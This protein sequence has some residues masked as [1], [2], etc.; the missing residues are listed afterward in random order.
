M[1]YDW[2]TEIAELS[3]PRTEADLVR[4]FLESPALSDSQRKE[5]KE[6]A[7]SIV[8]EVRGKDGAGPIER[9]VAG[10]DLTSDEGRA[11]MGLAEALV[12]VPD[13]RTRD[14]LIEDKVVGQ[15]WF[16]SDADALVKAAGLALDAAGHFIRDDHTSALHSAAHRLGMPVIRSS[17]VAAMKILGDRFVKAET[18]EDAVISAERTQDVLFSFDMLGEGARSEEDAKRHLASYERAIRTVAL[19]TVPTGGAQTNSGVS[20]KL[21]ALHC[22]YRAR[23]WPDVREVLLPR[24]VRLASLA[25][26]GNIPLAI[27]A[28]ESARLEVSLTLI[29]ELLRVPELADWDGLGIVLQ[30]YGLRAGEFLDAVLESVAE[31]GRQISVRLVKGAYWDSEI[32]LA[33]EKGLETFP[34]YTRKAHSDL[35]YLALARR[36]LEC[37]EEVF[38][39][40]ATHNAVTL[41]ALEMLFREKGGNRF[42]VQKL[43]GMGDAV[44]T[45]YHAKCSRHLRAYAPVGSQDDLLAYLVRRLLENAANASFLHQLGDA[46]VSE[47]DLVMDPYEMAEGSGGTAIRTG[48]GLFGDA[49]QNSRGRDLDRIEVLKA[50]VSACGSQAELPEPP[51]DAGAGD[52]AGA[53]EAAQKA[54]EEWAA[55]G[56]HERAAAIERIADGYEGA[57][58]ELLQL[59]VREAGKTMGDAVAELREAVDYCRY[60]AARARELP[61][62]AVPRGT[63]VAISPWNFPLAIFT[64]QVVAALAAGNAVVAKPA[65]QTPRVAAKA[66]DIMHAAGV[67]AGAMQLLCGPGGTVGARLVGAGSADMVAFTG[68]TE[69]ARLIHR[70]IAESAK[71]AAPLLAETAGI[72]A[73]VVDSTA[74]P[75]R[76]VDD[77]A[78][79][80][81][82]SAG[83]RCSSL[84]VLYLQEEVSERITDL[85]IGAASLLRVGD[86]ADPDTD[87]GPVIDAEAKGR[88]DEHVAKASADGSLL[89]Q[90]KAPADGNYCAPAII[91]V[92]GAADVAREVFGPVLHVATYPAGS[93][94]KVVDAINAAGYGLTMG[95]HSRMR[96]KQRELAGRAR[97]GNVYVNRNQVGAVVGCQ[98]FG[99]SGLSGTG[100]KAGGPLYLGAFTANAAPA[101]SEGETRLPGPDGEENV[102]FV[103]AREGVVDA[104]GAA[105][106]NAEALR[107][108]SAVDARNLDPGKHGELR[109]LLAASDGRI[110][111][112]VT[113][114]GGGCWLL[115]ER[116]V[117]TDASASGGNL[118]LLSLGA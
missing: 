27:D 95:L 72:N 117:C 30:G 97:V 115:E 65:E 94:D 48:A 99:G 87:I 13:E 47:D 116:T 3:P 92:S 78:A 35:S 39:Q 29:K 89:W 43:H 98:P 37:G 80:A 20:V 24:V 90:G 118:S 112:F 62:D 25:K 91:R 61:G 100:P 105:G 108:A 41:A 55:Q 111:P 23:S 2:L 4:G 31:S 11:M 63:V 44:H 22:R 14:A 107:Y 15:H 103:R 69:T 54:G 9:L 56:Y 74:L 32:K 26:E 104:S 21:S 5:A 18:I 83:Q 45:A 66:A 73:M 59:I 57:A 53:F 70:A 85:L 52:V 36:L 113:D 96:S 60:Y 42:E 16:A 81:F 77:V 82:L 76:V 79:S 58:D 19:G 64:G 75:E 68:S 88:I 40:F 8:S 109:R 67:P 10:F 51:P 12:R 6:L 110:V 106:L 17:L 7:R 101:V 84:R 34:V 49:R 86:P 38:P 71:P 1:A 33:Q 46:E 102:Y 50:T 114:A 28:E 93:E